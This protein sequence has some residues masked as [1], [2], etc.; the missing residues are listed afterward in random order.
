MQVQNF[1]EANAAHRLLASKTGKSLKNGQIVALHLGAIN[2][3]RNWPR[4]L[5]AL[6]RA[7]DSAIHI[8]V[9]GCV[10]NGTEEPFKREVLKLG[11]QHRVKFVPWIPYEDVSGYT[12]ACQLGMITFRSVHDNFM[13]AL[14]HKLFDYMLARLPVIDP[15]FGVEVADIVQESLM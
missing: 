7:K 13:Q 2:R 1:V 9:V 4:F 3:A 6:A 11:L 5:E 12:A 10:G 15:E 8:S 14:A